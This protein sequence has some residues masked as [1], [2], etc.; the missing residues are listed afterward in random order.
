MYIQLY[1]HH[2]ETS[3]EFMQRTLNDAVHLLTYTCVLLSKAAVL[4]LREG[5]ERMLISDYLSG[6]TALGH[7][8]LPL[9]HQ[10]Q[11][12]FYLVS[13]SSSQSSFFPSFLA[14]IWMVG[15]LTLFRLLAL[16]EVPD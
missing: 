5:C 10:S 16:L 11:S 2:N 14:C 7:W 3:R 1:E 6:G 12:P 15:K 13:I 4:A 8:L 9:F